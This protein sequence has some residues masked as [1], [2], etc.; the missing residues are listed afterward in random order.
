M[1]SRAA[2]CD[3]VFECRDR[4]SNP[5][6]SGESTSRH[7]TLTLDVVMEIIASPAGTHVYTVGCYHRR[8]V[9][10]NDKM[11]AGQLPDAPSE[12]SRPAADAAREARERWLPN[13]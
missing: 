2:K 3:F 5:R 9:C 8:R 11:A 7:G 6:T 12:R 1:I 4:I 10:L 13:G